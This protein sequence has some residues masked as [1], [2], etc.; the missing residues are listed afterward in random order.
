MISISKENYYGIIA[1]LFIIS[2]AAGLMYQVVWFKYLS[3]FLGNTTY[4]QTVVL[5]TFMGG[6]A[7]GASLWGRRADTSK[8]LLRIYAFLEI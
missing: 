2:G 7:I 4:A 3:L 6:L 8:H 5:A 1:L